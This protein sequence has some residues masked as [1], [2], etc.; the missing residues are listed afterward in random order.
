MLIPL[1][2]MRDPA[3]VLS[4]TRSV[5][6]FGGEI[7]E[8]TESDLIFIGLRAVTTAEAVQFDQMNATTNFICFGHWHDLGLLTSQDR[9]RLAETDE[10]FD[11]NGA[12]INDPKKGFTRLNLVLR[13]NG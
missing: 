7:I 12:P 8:Y 5:D 10:E 2:Q 6:E 4:P 1:G 11:I 13:E 3:V 9:I